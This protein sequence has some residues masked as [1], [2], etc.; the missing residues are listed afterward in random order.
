MSDTC[1]GLIEDYKVGIDLVDDE[2]D[3]LVGLADTLMTTLQSDNPDRDVVLMQLDAL[4][5]FS[6]SHFDHEETI[7]RNVNYPALFAHM[8]Q[9]SQLKEEFSTIQDSIRQTDDPAVWKGMTTIL[10]HWVQR[11]VQ[12]SDVQLRD[13]IHAGICQKTD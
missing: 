1:D 6:A 8:A 12:N 9:H 10:R 2:H 13:Y 5:E 7:M 11:H 4:Y 3:V